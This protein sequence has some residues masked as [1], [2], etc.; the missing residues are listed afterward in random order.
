VTTEQRDKAA[1]ADWAS[2]EQQA[3]RSWIFEPDDVDP[4]AE[5][6]EA[7]RQENAWHAGYGAGWD[8]HAATMPDREA[9]AERLG[10]KHG[11]GWGDIEPLTETAYLEMADAVLALLNEGGSA[12]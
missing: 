1:I 5:E 7:L 9:L 11:Y 3:Y 4:N 2:Q 12:E 6:V 8:A 10:A